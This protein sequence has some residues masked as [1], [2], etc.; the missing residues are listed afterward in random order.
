MYRAFFQKSLCSKNP[1]WGIFSLKMGHFF[2][3]KGWQPCGEGRIQVCAP[4]RHGVESP[5]DLH[6]AALLHPGAVV[7]VGAGVPGHT[8]SIPTMLVFKARKSRK[9]KETFYLPQL[10]VPVLQDSVDVPERKIGRS[11]R[12]GELNQGRTSTPGNS[13]KKIIGRMQITPP[14]YYLMSLIPPL[15]P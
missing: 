1:I 4:A 13:F 11:R 8:H 12:H 7:V 14:F 5:P 3:P 10:S 6:V 9:L 15:Y 2:V